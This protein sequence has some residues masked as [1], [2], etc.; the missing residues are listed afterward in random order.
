MLSVWLRTFAGDTKVHIA[1][2]LL[3][4]DFIFGIVAAVHKGTFRLSYLADFL[5]N[6]VLK[7]IGYFTFYSAALVAGSVDIVIP[8]LDFGVLAGSAYAILV[9]AFTG[10]IFASIRDLGFLKSAPLALVGG[11]KTIPVDLVTERTARV[12]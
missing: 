2:L 10:S 9:A 3:I 7:L 8:G 12:R 1:L 5:K 11:E 6:D 4:L